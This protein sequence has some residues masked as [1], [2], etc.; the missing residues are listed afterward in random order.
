LD[1]RFKGYEVFKISGEVWACCQPLPM[2]Q[3]LLNSAQ[4]YLK[5]PKTTKICLET[6]S[7]RN[8]EIPP[9][10]MILGFKKIKKSSM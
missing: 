2:Q 10:I 7:L 3:N 6:I 5:L 9:K 1:L 4:S 8:F